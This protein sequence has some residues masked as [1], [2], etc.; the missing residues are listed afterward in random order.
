MIYVTKTTSQKNNEMSKESPYKNGNRRIAS[1]TQKVSIDDALQL[2]HGDAIALRATQGEVERIIA[3]RVSDP[4]P[5]SE[6]EETLEKPNTAA[7]L[8]AIE[9]DLWW[10]LE[11]GE[12]RDRSD[13]L[14]DR[15]RYQD[16]LDEPP[17]D[18]PSC[19]LAGRADG[20][21]ILIIPM[22]VYRRSRIYYYAPDTYG[23]L[24]ALDV[25]DIVDPETLVPSGYSPIS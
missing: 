5:Q 10:D 17:K 18:A 7:S 23:T 1:T 14:V 6:V 13:E 12:I 11:D 16:F 9:T 21:V 19:S 3:G 24:V 8:A 22:P 2:K 4:A 25:G 20:S 15:P